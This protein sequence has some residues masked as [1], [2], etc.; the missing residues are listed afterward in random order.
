[1]GK[2]A[3][4]DMTM[5]TWNVLDKMTTSSSRDCRGER[6]AGLCVRV[7]AAGFAGAGHSPQTLCSPVGGHRPASR[8]TSRQT[9][10]GSGAG[11]LSPGSKSGQSQTQRRDSR[12]GE[13]PLLAA[14][15]FPNK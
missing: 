4:L 12:V 11:D 5:C 14:F 7:G 15:S 9:T 6:R 13:Q 3:F 10:S 8:Q 2:D 1:M